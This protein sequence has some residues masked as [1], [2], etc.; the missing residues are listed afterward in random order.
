MTTSAPAAVDP[1]EREDSGSEARG[2]PPPTLAYWIFNYAPQWEA[3]AK[4]LRLLS[5]EL[6][7][8]YDTRVVALNM[9]NRSLRVRGPEKTLPL[10]FA[11]LALPLLRWASSGFRINHIFAS[12]TERLLIPRMK[13]SR[14]MLTVTKDTPALGAIE[15]NLDH[16][17]DLRYVVV[18][19][20]WHRELLRQG[21]VADG[22]VRLIRPGVELRPYEE[23]GGR[24]RSCSPP[25]RC[26]D[27]TSSRG[28]SSSWCRRRRRF[29][30]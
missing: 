16:L 10:P 13:G 1:A 28:A 22:A 24:S 30:T 29:R 27:A 12:L 9:R 19:S 7:P 11:L 8:E 14:T 3:A 15:R 5:R 6:R 23:A 18:E 20:E 17:R 4:E 2:E 21:G 26:P 25:P